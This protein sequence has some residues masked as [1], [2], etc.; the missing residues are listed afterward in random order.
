MGKEGRRSAHNCPFN[1]EKV[2]MCV[3]INRPGLNGSA[4]PPGLRSC[5]TQGTVEALG[6]LLF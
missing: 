3:I 6:G 2:K 1:E 5:L 4:G